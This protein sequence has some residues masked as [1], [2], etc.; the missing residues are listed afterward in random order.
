MLWLKQFQNSSLRSHFW[1]QYCI[2]TYIYTIKDKKDKNCRQAED[3]ELKNVIQVDSNFHARDKVDKNVKCYEISET[4][5]TQTHVTDK[6]KLKDGLND[7]TI[8]QTDGF[9]VEIKNRTAKQ[10]YYEKRMLRNEWW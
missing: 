7:K 1:S 6:Y 4:L 8:G 2:F 3:A 9:V 10:M 5:T